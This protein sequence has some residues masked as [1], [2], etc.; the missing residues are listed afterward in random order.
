MP[1]QRYNTRCSPHCGHCRRR[2]CGASQADEHGGE[3]RVAECIL[4]TQVPL[5]L[6]LSY[7]Y[8]TGT[9]LC[10][11]SERITLSVACGAAKH[12]CWDALGTERK[13]QRAEAA[14]S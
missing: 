12:V 14:D 8:C 1:L 7:W 4:G 11:A 10:T 5:F 13:R 2:G 3:E 9:V 6:L